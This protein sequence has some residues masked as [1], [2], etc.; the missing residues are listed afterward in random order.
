MFHLID[1]S[2]W[3]P[4]VRSDACCWV[5]ASNKIL[6]D[7][8]ARLRKMIVSPSLVDTWLTMLLAKVSDA[9]IL[10]RFRRIYATEQIAVS[11]SLGNLKARDTEKSISARWLLVM[12]SLLGG[13]PFFSSQT[14]ESLSEETRLGDARTWAS[15]SGQGANSWVPIGDATLLLELQELQDEL[16]TD[17]PFVFNE[18][19]IMGECL[20]LGS[21]GVRAPE[22][23]DEILGEQRGQ[24]QDKKGKLD[25][26]YTTWLENPGPW[27]GAR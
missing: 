3:Y 6:A 14:C 11:A 24:R 12:T 5:V 27:Q 13:H 2:N 7:E 20:T 15:K 17:V 10:E 23:V 4:K 19:P 21:G 16:R 18:S 22:G 25:K 9:L 26:N 1:G 8:T